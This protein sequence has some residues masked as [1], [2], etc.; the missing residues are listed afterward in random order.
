MALTQIKTT[1]I[2]DDAVTTDKLA[3]AINTERTANTAKATNATHTGEVTGS[4]ALTIA[5]NVVDEANLKVSNSPTNGYFLQAQSGNDGGLTWAEAS[6]GSGVSD[7]DKGD[8]TVSSSGATWTIDNDAI[9]NAKVADDAIGVAELSATGTA[10]SS[11]YLRGDNTWATVSG[12]GGGGV[13]S[14][15]DGNTVAGTSAGE[16]LDSGEGLNNT[17]F[18]KDAGMNVTQGDSSVAVG[19]SALKAATTSSNNVAIGRSALTSNTAGE[20]VAVGAFA[21]G[22]QTTGFNNV[23]CGFEAAENLTTGQRC[24]MLGYEAGRATTTNHNVVA[25]GYQALRDNSDANAASFRGAVA[26]GAEAGRSN[27]G[28]NGTYIGFKS[29]VS[30]GNANGQVSIGWEVAHNNAGNHNVA[31]GSK[32]LY[33]DSDD[34]SADPGGYNIG[35]GYLAGYGSNAGGRHNIALGF[36]S[37]Y[38]RTSAA[39][40]VA[41]GKD[42]GGSITSSSDCVL[43]GANAGKTGT[44]DLTTGSNNILLGHDAAASSATVSNEITLGDSNISSLRCQVQA[45]S[46]LSD[47]RDKTQIEELPVGLDFV[48]QLKPVKFKWKSREGITKDGITESGFIAQDFQKAQKENDADYLGLVY[49]NN[50]DRLEASYGKLVPVLVKAIQELKMEIETL[51]NNG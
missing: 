46:S 29:G 9:T 32:A 50:P 2:A 3:N 30:S 22:A 47:E 25:V 23:A 14:D 48:S 10:S 4:G 20:T 7:G 49:D 13:T 6:G 17:F 26:V 28:Q 36:Q 19:E 45:I 41:I 51:K 42:A 34:G 24:V 12:G 8:I 31:I 11:T 27:T 37:M 1:A 21:L 43:I 39:S 18:G 15:S 16:D 35:I 44:N 33:T 5:D 40:V 38:A